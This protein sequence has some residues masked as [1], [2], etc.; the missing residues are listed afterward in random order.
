M[1]VFRFAD[2]L[3]SD[4]ITVVAICTDHRVFTYRLPALTE[5]SAQHRHQTKPDDGAAA[6]E[7]KLPKPEPAKDSS[8]LEGSKEFM[9]LFH[10]SP[11]KDTLHLPAVCVFSRRGGAAPPGGLSSRD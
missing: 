1:F 9:C 11:V 4:V 2:S 3:D 7:K 6:P 8:T 5:P 10:L